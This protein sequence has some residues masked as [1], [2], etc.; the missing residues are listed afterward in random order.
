ME[1]TVEKAD[2]CEKK[3]TI[4]KGIT[5]KV[6]PYLYLIPCIIIFLA[7]TYLPFLK[8][9]YL[10]LFNTNAEGETSSFAGLS[11]YINL[12]KSPTF[13][14]SIEVTIK[15]VILTTVPSIILALI[16]ALLCN[17]KLKFNGIFSTMYAMPMAVSSASASIIWLLL[18]NP[19]IGLVNYVLGRNIP[20]LVSPFWGLMAVSIVAV[21]MNIS[22]NFIFITAGLKNIPKELIES[23]AIDGANYLNTLKNVIL[24]CLSPTLFFVLIINII[25]GFQTFGQINIMTLGGPGQATN[26]LVYSIY[27]DA[28]FNN[29]FGAASAESIILFLI[30]LV[31]TLFQFRYEKNKVFY[32]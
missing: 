14:N 28:F 29:R 17:N 19:T 24:P 13:I 10:S 6:E 3:I 23:A 4:K 31:I 21:W 12:F 2:L 5:E 30:M 22:I 25:N 27:R 1:Q 16:I 11:N 7:F 32:S 9:M 15:F 26:V 8:T 18:F 20:W